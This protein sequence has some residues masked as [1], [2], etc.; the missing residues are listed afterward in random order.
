MIHI[1]IPLFI[2]ILTVAIVKDTH[3]TI[4]KPYSDKIYKEY[5]WELSIGLL[6]VIILVGLLPY[7]NIIVFA[8]C[9]CCYIVFSHNMDDSDYT[10]VL[11]LRG[12]NKVTKLILKIIEILKRK[13]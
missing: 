6:L 2:I 9:F 11:S 5:N 4:Y 3:V 7:V 8:V 10:P 1:F 12:D 13:I